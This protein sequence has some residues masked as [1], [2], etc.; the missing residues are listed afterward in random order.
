MSDDEQVSEGEDDES[1]SSDE[2]KEQQQ[3]NI[4]TEKHLT[5]NM[6]VKHN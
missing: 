4:F 1:M 3:L 6:E 2:T 5:Q